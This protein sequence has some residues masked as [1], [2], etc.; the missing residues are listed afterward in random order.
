[1]LTPAQVVPF[2]SHDDRIVRDHALSYLKEA[3]DQG[4][5]TADHFWDVID[6]FGVG[7]ETLS[8]M[9]LLSDVRQTEQS[10]R[11][12]MGALRDGQPELFDFHL[13]RAAGALDFPLDL[14]HRDE[15]LAFDK[16]L[17]HVRARLE[18]RLA[19]VDEPAG[20]L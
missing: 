12:L 9:S 14:E 7:D 16:L 10:Y 13:R 17:P 11:R 1:M 6:R 20:A 4:P 19:L 5:L 3:H 18:K 2:L 15:L 8:F